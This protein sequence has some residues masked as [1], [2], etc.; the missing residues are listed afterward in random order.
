MLEQWKDEFYLVYLLNFI[1]MTDSVN[2]VWC[3]DPFH[4]V[5]RHL[6]QQC[7]PVSGKIAID[8]ELH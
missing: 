1:K 7:E 4:S 3:V 6:Q 8:K 5:V 2:G